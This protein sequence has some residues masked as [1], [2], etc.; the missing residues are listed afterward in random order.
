LASRLQETNR[1][2]ESLLISG[3]FTPESPSNERVIVWISKNQPRTLAV[4]V[5]IVDI[6]TL[7]GKI[8]VFLY[9]DRRMAIREKLDPPVT[10]W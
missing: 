8:V 5:R 9:G 3:R 4:S 10:R 6:A 1:H 2:S 7:E